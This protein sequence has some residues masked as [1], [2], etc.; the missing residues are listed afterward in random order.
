M[1]CQF[2]CADVGLFR[3][4][5]HHAGFAFERCGTRL[6]CAVADFHFGNVGE[7][8]RHLS[9]ALDDG[10]AQRLGIVC[11]EHA[12]YDVLV[13]VFIED[14]AGGVAVHLL[15]GGDHLAQTDAVVLQPCRV[16]ECLVFLDFASEHRHLCHTS[17]GK[18]SGAHGP[19]GNCAQVAHGSGVAGGKGHKHQLAQDGR[20][21]AQCGSLHTRRKLAAEG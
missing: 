20:L 18:Q 19:I 12:A 8:Y 14:A 2:E 16:H 11:G 5:H 4:G 21:R 1:L 15:Y 13:A 7:C 17:R 6:R 3:H 10:F 9:P